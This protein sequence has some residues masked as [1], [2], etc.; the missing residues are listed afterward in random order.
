MKTNTEIT[1]PTRKEKEILN[2]LYRFHY[3]NRNQIQTLLNHKKFN[4][5]ISWLNELTKQ[6]YIA[7]Y[8]NRKFAG[9]PAIYC[10][11]I[12]ARKEMMGEKGINETLLNSVYQHK[13]N[14]DKFRKHCMFLADIYLS[15][16]KFVKNN[17]AKL[18]FY[19]KADLYKTQYL[20][21]PSPDSYFAIEDRNKKTK[22][23]FID[24]FDTS[25]NLKWAHK[26]IIQ[27]FDYYD[28][29]TWQDNTDKPFPE[30]VLVCAD[31]DDRKDL[32]KFIKKQMNYR[33]SDIYFYLST[34]D[35]IQSSGM[36]SK[37]LH[38]VE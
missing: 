7:R 28:E 19:T 23:Y 30:I 38:K 35:E 18:S 1:K 20:I 36:S 2:N 15:L 17:K 34:W 31:E 9:T 8:F 12:H 22:R 13:R 6:R 37:T 3:L 10:L 5:I 29:E 27:Y 11:D 24:I 21:Y 25:K 4:R 32:D 14:S 26:R 16:T 33:I